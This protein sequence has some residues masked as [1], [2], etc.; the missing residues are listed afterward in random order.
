MISAAN[1]LAVS[2]ASYVGEVR[3]DGF[4]ELYYTILVARTALRHVNKHLFLLPL[5]SLLQQ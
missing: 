5:G 2:V 4:G 1:S 3:E